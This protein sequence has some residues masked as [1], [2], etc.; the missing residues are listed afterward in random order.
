[1]NPINNYEQFVKLYDSYKSNRGSIAG[2]KELYVEM[3]MLYKD[4]TTKSDK[5]QTAKMIIKNKTNFKSNNLWDYINIEELN[6]RLY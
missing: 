5:K 2:E 3:I 6:S 4:A 1:M